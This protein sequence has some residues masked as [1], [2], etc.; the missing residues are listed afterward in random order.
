MGVEGGGSYVKH[1]SVSMLWL[2]REEK[3][4]QGWGSQ[5]PASFLPSYS[6]SS[7]PQESLGLCCLGNQLCD[8]QPGCLW[9]YFGIS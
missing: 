1:L 3:L 7:S 8:S 5:F 2:E 4:P 9:S 6:S